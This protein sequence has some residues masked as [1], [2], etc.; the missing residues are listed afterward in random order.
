LAQDISKICVNSK[1]EGNDVQPV[2]DVMT[3]PWADEA[4]EYHEEQ[5]RGRE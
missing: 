2:E 4:E 5:K 1:C 3:D